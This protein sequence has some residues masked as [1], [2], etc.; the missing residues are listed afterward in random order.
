MTT[1]LMIRYFLLTSVILLTSFTFHTN[2]VNP[3]GTYKLDNTVK[4][5]NGETYG[6]TGRIQVKKISDYL[7]VMTFEI[8]K[9]S[10]S[11]NS[12]SLVDTL[13]YEYNRS[14]YTDSIIDKSCK[15][16]FTFDKKGVTVKEITADF[17]SGCGFG[18]AVIADGYFKK[19]SSKTPILVKPLTGEKL[20]K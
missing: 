7:I 4:L 19:Y 12:G 13:N 14:I 6:Y 16:T 11:Y 1:R 15:I 10:P 20:E 9:G 2:P 18:G 5:K 17:N 8:Y 3:T